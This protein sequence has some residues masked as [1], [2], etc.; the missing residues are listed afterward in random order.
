MGA[1]S[2]S[3]ALPSSQI[4]RPIRAFCPNGKKKRRKGSSR[5]VHKSSRSPG[6][7]VSRCR[8]TC[9]ASNGGPYVQTI[10]PAPA[11]LDYADAVLV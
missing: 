11:R 1:R 8:P 2:A 9:V 3:A 6:S 4:S 10:R 7:G 5:T